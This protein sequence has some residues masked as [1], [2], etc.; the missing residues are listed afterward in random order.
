MGAGSRQVFRKENNMD[1]RKKIDEILSVTTGAVAGA[2]YSWE[3]HGG[4]ASHLRFGAKELPNEEWRWFRDLTPVRE[5]AT[6]GDC[7]RAE[8]YIGRVPVASLQGPG[9]YQPGDTACVVLGERLTETEY[10]QFCDLM[11][12]MAKARAKSLGY[13]DAYSFVGTPPRS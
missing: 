12:D 4:G 8:H 2:C 5:S 10:R 6:N 9:M 7:R 13:A 1:W 11:W 3:F